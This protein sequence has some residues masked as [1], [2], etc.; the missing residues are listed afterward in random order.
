MVRLSG[1]AISATCATSNLAV[2]SG[3][4]ECPTEAACG[5][6]PPHA[7]YA[8][9]TPEQWEPMNAGRAQ[10]LK[11]FFTLTIRHVTIGS[12][13]AEINQSDAWAKFDGGISRSS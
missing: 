13:R 8:F 6:E 2:R 12:K 4:A 1:R 9:V 10:R 5:H 7:C 3:T 11:F